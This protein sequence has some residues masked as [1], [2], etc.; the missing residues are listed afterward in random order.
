[1]QYRIGAKAKPY[2]TDSVSAKKITN[3]IRKIAKAKCKAGIPSEGF[4]IDLLTCAS[5]YNDELERCKS[6]AVQ[7]YIVCSGKY[8]VPGMISDSWKFKKFQYPNPEGFIVAALDLTNIRNVMI[9]E[10]NEVWTTD[11]LPYAFDCLELVMKYFGQD[12]E[13]K[14]QVDNEEIDEV[15]LTAKLRAVLSNNKNI[16]SNI[17][18][19]HLLI[20]D[21]FEP[22]T[23]ALLCMVDEKVLKDIKSG[24]VNSKRGMVVSYLRTKSG[25]S[26]E[27]C[28]S[29][30]SIW[31]DVVADLI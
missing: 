27:T 28:L 17:D 4:M 21:L 13:I 7:C 18:K 19:T 10:G 3:D 2:K 20:K 12:K 24:V 16:L 11:Y 15:I 9:H 22:K 30:L 26:N 5:K 23:A 25:K 8:R 1:M 29:I 6:L 14:P 31:E